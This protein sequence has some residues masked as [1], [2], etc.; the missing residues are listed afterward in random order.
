MMHEKR[1]Y[2]P[3]SAIPVNMGESPSLHKQNKKWEPEEGWDK[4]HEQKKK[5]EKREHNY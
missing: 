2:M 4:Y 1:K 5:L 3:G